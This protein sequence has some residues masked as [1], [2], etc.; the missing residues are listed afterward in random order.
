MSDVRLL[1][2][3]SRGTEVG[4]DD[5]VLL[6]VF[7]LL[8]VSTIYWYWARRTYTRQDAEQLDDVIS[9]ISSKT[10]EVA[11]L[12]DM[13]GVLLENLQGGGDDV[14]KVSAAQSDNVLSRNGSTS[15][16]NDEWGGQSEDNWQE[17]EKK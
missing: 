2:Q 17:C 12:V 6:N 14:V 13:V 7:D 8:T 4:S 11:E 3:G 5:S 15:T 10:A 1:L 9:Q 16:G